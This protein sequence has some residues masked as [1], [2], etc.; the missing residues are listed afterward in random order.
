ME[1][2]YN[3][4]KVT[5]CS[6]NRASSSPQ[7][8][9]TKELHKGL[10]CIFSHSHKKVRSDIVR[11]PTIPPPTSSLA[12]EWMW[13]VNAVMNCSLSLFSRCLFIFFYVLCFHL[14]WHFIVA[15]SSIII[16]AGFSFI[17]EKTFYYYIKVKAP[18]SFS[19]MSK[20]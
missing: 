5:L 7:Q 20:V 8:T 6:F 12:R 17:L 2:I 11:A 18:P 1:K 3:L 14:M 9:S 4:I 13:A 19:V 16:T 15:Q 10:H